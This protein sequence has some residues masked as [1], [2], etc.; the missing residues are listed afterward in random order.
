VG[1]F[2]GASA[3]AGEIEEALVRARAENRFLVLVL[4]S[5]DPGEESWVKD[6]L[7]GPEWAESIAPHAYRVARAS[8]HPSL[9]ARFDAA[10]FPQ[11]LLLDGDGREVGRLAGKRPLAEL[12]RSFGRM[13]K[14]AERCRER[15]A[16][17]NAQ[18]LDIE[19]LFWAG[20]Y[21]WNRGDRLFAVECFEKVLGKTDDRRISVEAYGHIA[22]HHLDC[23]RYAEAEKAFRDA[24]EQAGPEDRPERLALGLSLSL[25]R[26]GRIEEAALAIERHAEQ[27]PGAQLG[28]KALFTLGYLRNELGDHAAARRHFAACASRFPG[29][30]HGE[31]ARRYLGGAA[32]PPAA[33]AAGRGLDGAEAA[34]PAGPSRQ[35]PRS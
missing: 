9:A 1:V 28:A 6:D 32:E 13:V 8:E 23:G 26:Q 4:V 11:F 35:S 29:T 15:D 7:S 19:T 34:T 3:C 16:R 27:R 18:P 5:G 31:R 20:S 33:E 30:V 2:L 24:L 25:R 12:A 21:S 22:Q 14:A 10:T 17:G